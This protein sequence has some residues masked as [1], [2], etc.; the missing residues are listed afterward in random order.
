MVW[1]SGKD[2]GRCRAGS[3]TLDADWEEWI[4]VAGLTVP[5]GDRR[6]ETPTNWTLADDPLERTSGW[7]WEDYG[8]FAASGARADGSGR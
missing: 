2:G 4:W 7:N 5:S 8:T 1:F 3:G 6:N